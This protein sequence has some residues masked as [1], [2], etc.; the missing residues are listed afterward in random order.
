MHS[1]NTWNMNDVRHFSKTTMVTAKRIR[2]QWLSRNQ[3]QKTQ[4]PALFSLSSSP[5]LKNQQTNKNRYSMRSCLSKQLI[6][7]GRC[8]LVHG[9][10]FNLVT[11][12][13]KHRC[14]EIMDDVKVDGLKCTHFSR[15][16][17]NKSKNNKVCN[18]LIIYLKYCKN[19]CNDKMVRKTLTITG[20][21]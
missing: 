3:F 4:V 2:I 20:Y 13:K 16:P 10:Y 14:H 9:Y 18:L 21:Y 7:H 8:C 17:Q 12:Q 15:Y 19:Q 1:S 11:R 6:S 5:C